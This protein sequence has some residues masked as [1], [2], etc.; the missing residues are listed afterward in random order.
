MLL[1]VVRSLVG[2]PHTPSALAVLMHTDNVAP[3]MH[4]HPKLGD[5]PA[6]TSGL[7]LVYQ[8]WQQ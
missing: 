5:L 7:S 3:Y 2:C 6:L 4:M 1:F 8:R